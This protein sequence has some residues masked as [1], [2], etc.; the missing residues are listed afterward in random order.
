MA[1]NVLDLHDDSGEDPTLM[2]THEP[3]TDE[4]LHLG[5]LDDGRP[6]TPEEFA[7]ASYDEPWIYERVNG[8]LVV[9]S[10][11]GTR[12]VIQSE[13]WH[14]RLH[15]YSFLH[16]GIVQA[17]VSQAWI[18][19][20]QKNTRIADLGVYLGGILEEI[21]I[22]DQVPDL[23]FEFVS[24]SKADKRRDYVEKRADYE[25]VGVREDVIVD[26]FEKRVTV[27]SLVDRA[28]QERILTPADVYTSPL[29]P[30]FEVRL[31][32]VLPR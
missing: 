11:E 12:H 14:K 32:E 26:R 9:M 5:E 25:R 18:H 28:Y 16:S 1:N 17:V 10:P 3:T 21:N 30:G 2:A 6:T 20:D 23:V 15:V 27:L 22:P 31:A 7:S 8:R 29:L 4:Q 13:P 24:P 19:L